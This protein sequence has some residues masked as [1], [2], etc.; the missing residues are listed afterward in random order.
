LKN[1][2]ELKYCSPSDVKACLADGKNDF[3]KE[4]GGGSGKMD[5]ALRRQNPQFGYNGSV[6]GVKWVA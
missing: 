1:K 2:D 4:R 3:E 5:D 6:S